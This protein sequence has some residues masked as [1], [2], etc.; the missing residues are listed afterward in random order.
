MAA[1]VID[2]RKRQPRAASSSTVSPPG[3]RQWRMFSR[4]ASI[5]ARGI[6]YAD[7]HGIPVTASRSKIY[8]R[9]R[10]LWHIS[11]EGGA[12]ED[13]WDEPSERMYQLVTSP[14]RAWVEG[15]ALMGL[16]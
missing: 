1:G 6:D 16:K 12:L 15:R 2:C 13:P 7:A 4:H 3:G 5:S 8:S 11:H 9:D 14:E 10:N